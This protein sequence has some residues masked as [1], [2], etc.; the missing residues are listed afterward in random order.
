MEQAA[1]RLH[2]SNY[3]C[4]IILLTNMASRSIVRSEEPRRLMKM[5]LLGLGKR[6]AKRKNAD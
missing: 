4:E 1:Q 6:P 5:M 3:G 2:K